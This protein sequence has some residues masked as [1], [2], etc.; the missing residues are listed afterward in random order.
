VLAPV[1]ALHAFWRRR[2][3]RVQRVVQPAG[4]TPEGH[5]GD[6]KLVTPL[7]LENIADSAI[8]EGLVTGDELEAVIDELYRL[9]SDTTTVLAIPRIVQAWG[10]RAAG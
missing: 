6:I 1:A 4:M 8:A 7:T 10:Y 5:E 3:L 2:N 9:A